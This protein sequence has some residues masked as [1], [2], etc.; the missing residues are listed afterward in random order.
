MLAEQGGMMEPTEDGEKGSVGQV[1]E[2]G[3]AGVCHGVHL[4]SVVYIA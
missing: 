3:Q 1:D 4:T 2:E